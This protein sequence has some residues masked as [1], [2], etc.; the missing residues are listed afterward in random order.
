VI[1]LVRVELL[2]FASRR[3]TQVLTALLLVGIAVT[4]VIVG[5]RSHGP[6][7]A[8]YRSARINRAAN[9]E[10]CVQDP[11]GYG[12]Q[13]EPGE[14][15]EQACDRATPPLAAWVADAGFDLNGLR[16]IL[17][18]TSFLLAAVGLILGAS[19]IGAEW[20][21]G[22]VA[23]LLTWEP[24]RVRVLLIKAAAC[25]AAVFALLLALEV[26]FCL[27]LWLDAATRGITVG[28]G[29]ASWVRSIV[30]MAAR[31]AAIGAFAAAVGIAVAT[32]GRN[33]AAALGAV[34]VYFAIVE[35]LISGLRPMWQRWLI[36]DNVALFLTGVDNR[37]PP[38]H[39]TMASSGVVL[40][41]YAAALLAA[42]LAW[43]RARDIT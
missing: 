16:D 1:R 34:F 27:V 42:A 14:T 17:L 15:Q 32:I 18:G 10:A 33:T 43:F 36:G 19:F 30:G 41:T 11:R 23:T 12:V 9:V 5:V 37:Y 13:P 3:L 7:A 28:T 35:R 39:R 40:V 31:S 22:T 24:R 6:S 26:V 21:W 29:S 20:H 4:G 25:V 8:E 2:R 38:L